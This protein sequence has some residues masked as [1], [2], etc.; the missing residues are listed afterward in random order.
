MCMSLFYFQ[1]KKRRKKE[2]KKESVLLCRSKG[3]PRLWEEKQFIL[4]R[5]NQQWI[6]SSDELSKSI[7]DMVE[8]F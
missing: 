2:R 8:R 5:C 4:N 6:L 7:Y 3:E 1:K